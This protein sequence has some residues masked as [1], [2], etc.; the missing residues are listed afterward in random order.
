MSQILI[1]AALTTKL[2][3][4]AAA[5]NPVL[6]IAREGQAF[7]KPT[8]N[9]PWLEVMLHPAATINPTTEATR[10]RYLGEFSVNVWTKDSIGTGLGE[11]IAEEIAALFPVVPKSLLPISVEQ[12]PSIKKGFVDEAGWRIT[13]VCVQY[14]AEY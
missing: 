1:R 6:T 4:W 11:G 12:T 7:T 3:T 2:A 13:P 9:S 14:R 5:H 8:D 10:K